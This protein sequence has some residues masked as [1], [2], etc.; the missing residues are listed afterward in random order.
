MARKE[1]PAVR[2]R[3]LREISSR[4]LEISARPLEIPR[5]ATPR[6]TIWRR[7]ASRD[8]R[9]CCWQPGVTSSSLSSTVLPWPVAFSRGRSAG[10]TSLS[11]VK[12][13]S[14]RVTW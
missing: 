9:H 7:V 2:A 1:R 4:P 6:K 11:D 13:S 3:D 12:L 5:D 14:A 8:A 10:G